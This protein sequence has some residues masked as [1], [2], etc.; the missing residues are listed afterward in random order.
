MSADPGPSIT[1]ALR[2]GAT[3][4]SSGVPETAVRFPPFS[5]LPLLLVL[6]I[7]PLSDAFYDYASVKYAYMGILAFTA[8]LAKAGQLLHG[9]VPS[10]AAR[11]TSFLA[12]VWLIA[13]Y[14]FCL[15]GLIPTS[16][17]PFHEAFKIISPFVFFLL[18]A[19]IADRWLMMALVVA[20]VLTIGINA[21]LLPTSFGWVYWGGVHTFKGYY[22]F[23]TDLAYALTFSVLIYA[24]ATRYVIGGRLAVLVLLAGVQIVLANSRLNYLTFA[25][26]VLF[27]AIKSGA[28]V[29]NLI[30][31]AI[32]LGLLALLAAVLYD[33]GKLL[34]FDTHDPEAFTQGRSL[35]W[36][37]LFD[38]LA[39]NDVRQWIFG[40]GMFADLRLS[41]ESFSSDG[42]VYDAHNEYLHLLYTQGFLGTG[43][44]L[45]LWYWIF[46]STR[47]DRLPHWARGTDIVAVLLVGLQGLTSVV[48]SY[49]TKTWPLVMVFLTLRALSSRAD[50]LD[51]QRA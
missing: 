32:L 23:K 51:R 46:R 26:V 19:P 6:C 7:K 4:R 14:F 20:S 25:L 16:G 15:V 28:N 36:E 40:R 39:A 38:S 3:S 33:P 12:L 49:A 44:Y 50:A 2:K 11:R 34:G 47:V 22:Y 10:D 45:G 24:L 21:A 29:R 5:S 31:Y 17:N 1:S 42:A 9:G 35:I 27:C 8:L 41:I 30:R 48:S 37:R 18:V 43:L 13:L